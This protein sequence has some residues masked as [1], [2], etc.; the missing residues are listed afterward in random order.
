MVICKSAAELEKMHQAGLIVWGALQEVRT[1][2][3]PGISTQELDEF[4]EEYT[5][6]HKA[7]P[8]FKG[9]HGYPGS[10]CTS[11][12]EEVVHGIPSPKRHVKEGDILS[13]D[14]GV[15]LDGYSADAALTVPV[16]KI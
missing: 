11:I 14:F 2:V 9:Y 12:N 1:L 16:G 3:E 8:A 5:L 6:E 7:K 4:A 13:L 10:V 15:E